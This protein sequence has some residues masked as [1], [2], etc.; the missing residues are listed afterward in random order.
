[1]LPNTKTLERVLRMWREYGPSQLQILYE[2]T[3]AA[4]DE[5]AELRIEIAVSRGELKWLT[6]VEIHT[7]EEGGRRERHDLPVFVHRFEDPRGLSR[8]DPP[9]VLRFSREDLAMSGLDPAVRWTLVAVVTAVPDRM[10]VGHQLP[11]L[12]EIVRGDQHWGRLSTA[13]RA[14]VSGL[15]G[16]MNY[17]SKHGPGEARRKLARRLNARLARTPGRRRWRVV[18][19]LNGR[20]VLARTTEIR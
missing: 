18:R 16:P 17:T 6:R 20:R 11:P 5:T 8:Q 4:G 12:F 3:D 1:M 15:P 10:W 2:V 13:A 14:R 7:L 9:V 19:D